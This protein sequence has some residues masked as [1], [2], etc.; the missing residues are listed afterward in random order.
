MADFTD[1]QN[2]QGQVKLA[3]DF[4]AT[5][6]PPRGNPRTKSAVRPRSCNHFPS[7][8]PASWREAKIITHVPPIPEKLQ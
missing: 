8:L 7:R 4:R 1:D 5:T 2:V 3:R 6:T